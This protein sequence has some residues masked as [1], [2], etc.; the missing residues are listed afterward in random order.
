[1]VKREMYLQRIR[2]FYESE[3]IKVISG[4]RRCGKSTIMKQIIEELR[5]DGISDEHI[6]YINFENYK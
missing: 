3:M 1:M 4:I 6:I 5:E 2:P